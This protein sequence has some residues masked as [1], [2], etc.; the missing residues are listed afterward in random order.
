MALPVLINPRIQFFDDN[1]NPLAGGKVYTY[2]ANTSTPKA[3]YTT[4]EGTTENSN[5]VVLDVR[6]ES[7]IFL[8]GRYSTQRIL[9][10]RK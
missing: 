10:L 6:G 2:E 5:P 9:K 3:T 1:G 8:S 7:S 4:S